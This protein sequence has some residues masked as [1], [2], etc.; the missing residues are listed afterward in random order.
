MD[1]RLLA[2]AAAE[3]EATSIPT[4]EWLA[5]WKDGRYD[6]ATLRST[7]HYK[8][9]V[10]FEAAARATPP[11]P[12]PPVPHSFPAT[13]LL[14]EDPAERSKEWPAAY[15]RAVSADPA[16]PPPSKAWVAAVHAQGSPVFTWCDC[17]GTPPAAAIDLAAELGA[18]GWIGQ[19]ETMEQFLNAYA[20]GARIVVGNASVLTPEA[21]RLVSSGAL[22]FVNELYANCDASLL[23]REDWR[24]LPVVARIVAVYQDAK[25]TTPITL[26]GYRAAGKFRDGVDWVYM[27]GTP[28]PVTL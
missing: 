25:C 10:L 11:T 9:H 2:Q 5:R 6:L 19:A 20:A 24:G 18:D 22:L 23:T 16:Y 4:D 17:A 26:D 27:G 21:M 15:A 12:P 13:L 7:H 1:A 3:M 28:W 8:A 14:A